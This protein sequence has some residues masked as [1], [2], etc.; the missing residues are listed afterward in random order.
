VLGLAIV[1]L[2]H[3]RRHVSAPFL[4][5]RGGPG[6]AHDN[7]E[8]RLARPAE[9]EA[10]ARRDIAD[11]KRALELLH[12][13]EPAIA[14][15]DGNHQSLWPSGAKGS[16]VSCSQLGQGVSA[17]LSTAKGS[18]ALLPST[19]KNWNAEQF[20]MPPIRHGIRVVEAQAAEYCRAMHKSA[21]C[22]SPA[23]TE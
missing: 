19:L 23:T 17:G 12:L 9:L 1:A 2:L 13:A 6:H 8:V 5:C 4:E 21:A 15:V 20:M 18:S 10:L 11:L 14:A 16:T 22:G 7:A 3:V